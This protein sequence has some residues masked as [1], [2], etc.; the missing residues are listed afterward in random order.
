MLEVTLQYPDQAERIVYLETQLQLVAV[1]AQ[2]GRISG[3]LA[4]AQAGARAGAMEI[5]AVE[6][7][8]LVRGLEGG[9]VIIML[10]AAVVAR[11][12]MD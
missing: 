5:S 2:L 8:L 10:V 11:V 4:G 3:A 12:S 7:E 9:L 6:T 1:A